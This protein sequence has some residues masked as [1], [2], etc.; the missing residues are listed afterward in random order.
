MFYFV[1]NNFK[2]ESQLRISIN[3]DEILGFSVEDDGGTIK[4][5]NK[6]LVER[7]LTH[8]KMDNC[9]MASTPLLSRLD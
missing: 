6:P 5:H 8:F 4:L 9:K 2:E 1:I 3:I 7:L